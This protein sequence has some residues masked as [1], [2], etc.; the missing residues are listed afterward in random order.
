MCFRRMLRLLLAGTPWILDDAIGKWKA[1]ALIK[2]LAGPELELSTEWPRCPLYPIDG[3]PHWK[4]HHYD[5][6]LAGHVLSPKIHVTECYVAIISI[7]T[8][9]EIQASEVESLIMRTT[10]KYRLSAEFKAMLG[11]KQWPPQL[12]SNEILRSYGCHA[13]PLKGN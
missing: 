12:P 11:G 7:H 1:Q 4:E 10:G 2:L 9:T 5:R 6:A 8:G 3:D 13:N